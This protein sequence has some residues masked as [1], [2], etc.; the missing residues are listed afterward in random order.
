MKKDSEI[1]L[2]PGMIVKIMHPWIEE[3][4]LILKVYK[5]TKISS[6]EL[7]DFLVLYIYDH[8]GEN[9]CIYK[10]A[11]TKHIKDGKVIIIK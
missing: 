7:Y 3:Y 11:A 6:E 1:K 9:N 2:K 8:P 4:R 10:G 5:N